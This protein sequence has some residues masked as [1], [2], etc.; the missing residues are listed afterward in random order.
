MYKGRWRRA[1]AITVHTKSM[2][3]QQYVAAYPGR[4]HA[5]RALSWLA[6]SVQYLT[7]GVR[8]EAK[9]VSSSKQQAA[10]SKHDFVGNK[11]KGKRLRFATS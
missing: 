8:S 5:S 6:K 4:D 10:S 9:H 3:G 7:L 1:H 2:E 11:D